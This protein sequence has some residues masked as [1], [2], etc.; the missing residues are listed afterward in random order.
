FFIPAGSPGIVAVLSPVKGSSVFRDSCTSAP[1]LSK[2]DGEEDMAETY[3][4]IPAILRPTD[5]S[6]PPDFFPVSPG[7]AKA[8]AASKAAAAAAAGGVPRTQQSRSRSRSG[9]DEDREEY[10]RVRKMVEE[11]DDDEDDEDAAG[12]VRSGRLETLGWVS[13]SWEPR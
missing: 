10:I 12:E 2:K 1:A 13:A 11:E 9:D 5:R 7:T 3:P 8:K 6:P 4:E